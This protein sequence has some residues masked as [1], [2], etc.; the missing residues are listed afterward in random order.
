MKRSGIRESKRVWFRSDADDM[1]SNESAQMLSLKSLLPLHMYQ[2]WFADRASLE[3]A[4]S[5][6]AHSRTLP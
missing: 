5:I 1:I 6:S 2:R 4:F 3:L